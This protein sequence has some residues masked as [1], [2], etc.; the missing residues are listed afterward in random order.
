VYQDCV[1]SILFET[2]QPVINLVPSVGFTLSVPISSIV[3]PDRLVRLY[4]N[5]VNQYQ[6][7]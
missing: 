5:Q 2:H 7:D 1:L 3:N 6:G 4:L